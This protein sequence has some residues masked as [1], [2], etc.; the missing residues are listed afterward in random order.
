LRLKIEIIIFIISH[1]M[2]YTDFYY[3]SSNGDIEHKVN[4]G[5]ISRDYIDLAKR[6]K[7]NSLHIVYEFQSL[8]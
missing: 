1:Q 3:I 4:W 5:F 7:K 6:K 2:Y 8:W